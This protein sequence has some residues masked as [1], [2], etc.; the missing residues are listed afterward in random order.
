[1]IFQT[2]HQQRKTMI[3]NVLLAV[4]IFL[5]ILQGVLCVGGKH[6]QRVMIAALIVVLPM[7]K[8]ESMSV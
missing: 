8:T 1:M 4:G 6:Q 3:M 2:L 7:L 5:L